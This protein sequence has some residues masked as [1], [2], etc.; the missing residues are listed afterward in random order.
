MKTRIEKGKKWLDEN[1]SVPNLYE[2]A[3]EAWINLS[4]TLADQ[5]KWKGVVKKKKELD[6]SETVSQQADATLDKLRV[7]LLKLTKSY[8]PEI[9]S[10][11]IRVKTGLGDTEEGIY[12]QGKSLAMLSESELW[13]LFLLIWEQKDVSFVFCENVNSLGS[14]AVA[15]LNKLVKEGA[16]VFASEML[17]KQNH[18]EVS[19]STK[20]D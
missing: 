20:I 2:A 4:K 11:E 18:M 13:A 19:F 9:P 16:Q 8:L 5:E 6:D 14:D 10:L 17:R 3:S 7:D 12:Y 15:I 1:K